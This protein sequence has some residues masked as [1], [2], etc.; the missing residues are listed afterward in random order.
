MSQGYVVI[1]GVLL[2]VW[3]ESWMKIRMT[4][5][6]R[7]M[8]KNPYGSSLCCDYQSPPSRLEGVM[9]ENPYESGLSYGC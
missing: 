2:V 8:D 4:S 5:F 3:K 1:T 6:A 7:D 9:D